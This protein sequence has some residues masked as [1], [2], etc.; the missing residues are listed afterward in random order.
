[1]PH[2]RPPTVNACAEVMT[3][4]DQLSPLF[5][6]RSAICESDLPSTSRHVA[7]VLSL[8]MSERGDSCFPS[9]PTLADESG[10]SR[11]TVQRHLQNLSDSGWLEHIGWKKWQTPGG[12]QRTKRWKAVVPR[13]RHSD[14][15]LGEGGESV[16]EGGVRESERGR[17][18]DTQGRYE[19]DKGRSG[20][21]PE[22]EETAGPRIGL[23]PNTRS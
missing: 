6:W 21:T 2:H 19:G 1:M 3:L 16:S 20:R 18:S 9:I 10:Y 13:G 22:G 17:H 8:H 14:T 11:R 5:T 4:P 12:E 7:L 15:P 23:V